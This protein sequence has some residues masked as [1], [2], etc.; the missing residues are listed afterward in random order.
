GFLASPSLRDNTVFIGDVEG[1]VYA[2]NAVSGEEKWKSK[3]EGEINGSVNF[4][5]DSVLVASQDGKLYCFGVDQGDL[6]WTYET[7]DSV[8]CS[9]SIATGRTFLG[10]CDGQLHQVNL[11]TGEAIGAPLPLGGPT[12]ST[13]AVLQNQVV[14]PIMDGL[15]LAF[16]WKKGRELWRYEDLDLLQEYRSSAAISKD[17]VVV[18]SQNRQVDALSVDTGKLKWRYTL[19]RRSDA[20]PVIAGEDVWIAASDG[21]LI[22]LSLK[23]GKEKW[24]YEVRGS[25]LAAPAIVGDELFIGDD[26][27]ILRC[28]AK[29]ED[30]LP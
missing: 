17:F 18:S 27:G 4:F 30:E 14:L 5:E 15:V 8:R 25:F 13:P 21:R 3:T 7:Q 23:D 22:R 6:R 24:T 19:K 20:S 28:F 16:D 10:G 29:P 11:K 12:G 2:L 9:P 1:S 26:D